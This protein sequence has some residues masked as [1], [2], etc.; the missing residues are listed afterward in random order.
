ME[1]RKLDFEKYKN[2]LEKNDERIRFYRYVNRVMNELDNINHSSLPNYK[3]QIQEEL[4]EWCMKNYRFNRGLLIT[5]HLP[6]YLTFG[7]FSE[8]TEMIIQRNPD[9]YFFQI[10]QILTKFFR[11]LERRVYKSGNR[12]LEKFSVI[13]GCY[14]KSKRNHIHTIVEIPEHLSVREFCFLVHKSHGSLIKSENYTNYLITDIVEKEEFESE[15]ENQ[16]KSQVKKGFNRCESSFQSKNEI[17]NLNKRN[18][19]KVNELGNIDIRK[20]DSYPR[21]KLYIYLTKEF[22]NNRYTVSFKNSYVKS[23]RCLDREKREKQEKK[24]FIPFSRVRKNIPT[25][26]E[27]FYVEDEFGLNDLVT[28]KSSSLSTLTKINEITTRLDLRV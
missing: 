16:F 9:D 23:L 5:I 6:S 17:P 11:R 26:V 2:N 10:E 13:E 20:L 28:R 21:Q 15:N 14:T 22:K 3:S 4:V 25:T 7:R 24:K 8:K 1:K 18:L 19:R 27:H 12:R